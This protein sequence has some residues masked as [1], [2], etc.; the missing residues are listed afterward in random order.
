VDDHPVLHSCWN[1]SPMACVDEHLVLHS[2]C[3][4][5]GP[6][7]CSSS[8]LS[9]SSSASSHPLSSHASWMSSGVLSSAVLTFF[10]FISFSC[11]L[12]TYSCSFVCVIQFMLLLK[13][14][15]HMF[16]PPQISYRFPSIIF[17]KRKVTS[18][19]EE[20]RTILRHPFVFHFT[21]EKFCLLAFWFL[22]G[23]TGGACVLRLLTHRFPTRLRGRL[24]L[25]S[26]FT[27]SHTPF[28]TI[29]NI[30][31]ITTWTLDSETFQVT[32]KFVF[33]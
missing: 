9:S 10:S 11:H 27:P 14:T 5:P 3:N 24:G 31:H 22:K 17:F 8:S 23:V 18:P 19:D 4:M 20:L 13:L 6:S 33:L 12:F 29:V 2:C 32:G 1:M 26:S 28:P 16:R 21:D 25:F 7:P 30:P 15:D